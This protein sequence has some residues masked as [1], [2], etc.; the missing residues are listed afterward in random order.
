MDTWT[1]QMG[2]PVV[3]VKK[4]GGKYEVTQERFL[5]DKN[6]NESLKYKSPYE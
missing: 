3:T 2:Y 4:S 1:L 6:A 5:Y